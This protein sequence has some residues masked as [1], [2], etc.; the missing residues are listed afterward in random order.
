MLLAAV[1]LAG[2]AQDPR[3]PQDQ[4]ID[5]PDMGNSA[6][7]FLSDSEEA[8]YAQAMLMQMRAYGMLVNDPLISGYFA[9]MG[10]RLVANSDK[11]EQP[12][13]F[14]VLNEPRVNAFAAPGGVIALHSGLILA[15]ETEHEVAGVVAH[16]IAHITQLHLYRTLQNTQ[17][18]TIPIALGMLAIMVAG[19][20]S[21]QAITGALVAGQG[22][23]TQ[24]YINFT[25]ANEIEADRIGMTTLSLSG[26][27]PEGMA[28]FF[29]RLNRLNRVAGEGPPEF[30]RTHPVTVNRIAEAKNRAA[31]L[32]RPEYSDGLDFQLAQSR[33]RA[34]FD[35][36]P[37][38]AVEWFR[39]ELEAPENGPR[40]RARQYGL[41]IAL[42]RLRQFDEA[43][44][45]LE[46]L[47]AHDPAKLAYR[48]QMASLDMESGQ[49]E[50]ALADLRELNRGFP[51]N[52]AIAVQ[53]AEALLRERDAGRAATASEVLRQQL[54]IRKE[55]PQLHELYA[56][57]SSI[58]GQETRASEA[59]AK[60][61]FLSG[62]LEEAIQQL[63]MLS[64]RD[65]L[66]YYQR[67]RVSA[68]LEEMRIVAAQFDEG[69]QDA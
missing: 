20:G 5:L 63:E 34:L 2:V 56:R 44:S 16:E 12:F 60:S 21:G 52:H 66:D 64:R 33:L 27:D 42:Q 1:S 59:L 26:Y 35:E 65:D 7:N 48:L 32:P 55:D 23:S 36:Q 58:A 22:M 38:D 40:A 51:G 14:V 57:A 39:V 68:R 6:D 10:F 28:D 30:L 11:P 25:R 41:A 4:R 17:N 67:A 54:L 50:R 43:R 29:E 24:A 13:T 31:G 47:L 53:Y 69:P 19:G 49:L 3:S 8:E 45:L 9:D 62:D 61:Y 46:R 15:A 37:Q 18:M